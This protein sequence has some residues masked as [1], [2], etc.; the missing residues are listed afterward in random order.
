L[1]SGKG[2]KRLDGPQKISNFKSYLDELDDLYEDIKLNGYDVNYPITVSIGRNGEWM[3]NHGNH[4]H[5]MLKSIDT[6]LVPVRIKYR[7]KQ[8]QELRYDIYNNGFS[9]EH[10]EELRNHPDIQDMFE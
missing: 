6:G 4:R 10:D 5:T 3:I 2:L 1:E 8:W 7:H 9:E